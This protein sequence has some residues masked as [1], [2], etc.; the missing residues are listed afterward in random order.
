[1]NYI[2]GDVASIF[3]G[4]NANPELL[5]TFRERFGLNRPLYVRYVE[6]L[7]GLLH[8]SFGRSFTTGVDVGQELWQ[9]FPVTLELALLAMLIANLVGIPAGIAAATRHRTRVDTGV[10]VVPSGL[11]S[12]EAWSG[13]CFST[14]HDMRPSAGS[15]A[16]TRW[17]VARSSSS[18]KKL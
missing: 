14:T 5:Q 8:G 16:S 15:A 18:A 7:V 4:I 3:L 9:R 2:P 13:R 17:A 12:S 10:S 6:W 11:E 1:M